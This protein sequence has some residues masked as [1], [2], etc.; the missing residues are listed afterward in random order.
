VLALQKTWKYILE[1]AITLLP[2]H[3]NI[4]SVD[5]IRAYWDGLG[6]LQEYPIYSKRRQDKWH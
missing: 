5:C 6:R 4:L 1:N 2:S 3:G